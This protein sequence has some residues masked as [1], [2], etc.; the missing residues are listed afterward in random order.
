MSDRR[1]GVPALLGSSVP[2]F[3]NGAFIFGYPG[4]LG[5]HWQEVFGVGRGHIGSMLFFLL[6]AV[7][8]FMFF[9]GRWQERFGARKMVTVGA[10]ICGLDVF[11]TAYASNLFMLYLWAFLMGLASCFI[12]LPALTSVQR[13]YPYKRGLVSGFV[14]FMFGFAGAVMAP[15]FNYLLGH[16][17]YFSMNILLGAVGLVAG[18]AAAQL[19]DMPS[20][21]LAE[22]LARGSAGQTPAHAPARSLTVGQSVRTRSFWLLWSIWSLQGAGGIGMVTLSTQYGLSL[23]M[24]LA[25]AVVILTAFNFTNGLSRIAMGV[26]SDIIGRRPTMSVVFLAVGCA[27]LVLP[28]VSATIAVAALAAVIGCGLGTLFAVS[29]P[30]ASDC[31][32]LQH[33]GA[34]YGLVFTAYGFVA[35]PLGPSLG[36][37]I[38]DATGGNFFIVFSYLGVFCLISGVLILFVVPPRLDRGTEA[39]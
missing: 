23:G 24:S 5:S 36:G 14:N 32:G 38:L 16:M 39:L 13:W 31:F 30:L 37:F 11:L 25:S 34:I 26:L 3:F 8:I 4:V 29:A 22:A 35:G 15:V 1:S 7:G 12:Y 28:H 20:D 19:T 6:A 33:F 18:L 10:A 9:V 17:G 2:I 27:Y 21:E